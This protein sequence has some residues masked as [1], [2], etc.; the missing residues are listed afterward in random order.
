MERMARRGIASLWIAA[1]AAS[2][3]CSFPRFAVPGALRPGMKVVCAGAR[4]KAAVGQSR[5]TEE[6]QRRP[7]LWKDFVESLEKTGRLRILPT[8]PPGIR[9]L[10]IC[11]ACDDRGWSA[12]Q[13]RAAAADGTLCFEVRAEGDA[14]EIRVASFVKLTD[15][16]GSL[17]WSERV[18]STLRP[19]AGEN[20][21]D[22]PSALEAL[23]IANDAKLAAALRAIPASP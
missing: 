13:A 7:G 20:L 22:L 18:E 2:A 10:A 6:M 15:R 5:F 23:A 3:G 19:K 9:S 1:V 21:Q 11:G 12:E 4:L 17:V 14:A 8:T 16:S